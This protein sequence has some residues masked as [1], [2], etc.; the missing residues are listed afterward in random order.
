MGKVTVRDRGARALMQRVEKAAQAKGFTVGIHEEQAGGPKEGSE[1]SE[2][3][4]GLT[5][6]EVAEIHEFGTATIPQ[7]SFIGAYAEGKEAEAKSDLRKL[8]TAIVKGKV[9]AD[10]GL[11]QLAQLYAGEV[12]QRIADGIPPGLADSTIAKKGSSTPLIGPSGQLRSS[13]TGQVIR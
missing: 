8:A 13:I 6:I 9:D 2:G 7:R 12:Q 5:L 3:S 4:E 1:G 10:R 11:D